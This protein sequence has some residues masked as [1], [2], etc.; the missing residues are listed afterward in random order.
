MY[1]KWFEC[2]CINISNWKWKWINN[3]YADNLFLNCQNSDQTWGLTLKYLN[4]FASNQ[5][6]KVFILWPPP[7]LYNKITI[8]TEF[9]WS[10]CFCVREYFLPLW[11][12]V[13]NLYLHLC[14]VFSCDI[15]DPLGA[16]LSV[17]SWIHQILNWFIQLSIHIRVIP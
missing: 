14:V 4:C 9:L 6:W 7:L 3:S 10:Q 17:A 2:I 16:T 13:N 12:R 5:Y 15:I 8:E 1:F 11:K